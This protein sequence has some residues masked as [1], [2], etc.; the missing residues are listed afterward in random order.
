MR[1][2]IILLAL[3]PGV[4]AQTSPSIPP[5]T[6]T[7]TSPVKGVSRDGKI[8]L[9]REGKHYYCFQESGRD[10]AL[11]NTQPTLGYG[12][13]NVGNEK[14]F[15]IMFPT[16]PNRNRIAN[17]GPHSWAEQK[18]GLPLVEPYPE[19]K[20][21]EIR[22]RAISIATGESKFRQEIRSI[23]FVL[24]SGEITEMSSEIVKVIQGNMYLIRVRDNMYDFLV[25]LRVDHLVPG[26]SVTFSWRQLRYDATS[27]P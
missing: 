27:W 18:I 13:V 24:S 4:F 26:R 25:L 3:A 22:P 23:P 19:A 5:I 15:F 9:N 2:L 21:G 6:A 11:F 16:W 10:C 7:L 1:I 14:D 20:P 8:I 12:Y 17:I